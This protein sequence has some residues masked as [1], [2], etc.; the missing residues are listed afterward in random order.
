MKVLVVSV[1]VSSLSPDEIESLK[2]A[3]ET[4]AEVDYDVPIL[5]SGVKS[6]D[7]SFD[8]PVH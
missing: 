2:I 6:I 3:M 5:N 7:D 8:N 1:D 4:Q